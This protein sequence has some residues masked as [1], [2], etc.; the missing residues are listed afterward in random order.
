[1]T[2]VR[3][4]KTNDVANLESVEL[5]QRLL[6]LLVVLANRFLELGVALS[7]CEGWAS[8]DQTGTGGTQCVK[9]RSLTWLG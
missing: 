8:T 4:E 9:L 7:A 6:E 3:Q 1:M 5:L 2:R